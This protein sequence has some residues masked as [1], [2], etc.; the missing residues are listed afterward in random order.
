M[1]RLRHRKWFQRT[2]FLAVLALIWSQFA[3]ASHGACLDAVGPPAAV[4]AATDTGHAH[5]HGHAHAHAPGHHCHDVE[6]PSSNPPLCD[7]HC[8]EDD[9][10]ADSSRIPPV[11]PLLAGAWL[12]WFA[13][14]GIA[15]GVPV[16]ASTL[17]DSPPRPAWHRPTAHPAALLL[18]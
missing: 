8:A 18:I 5:M 2:A 4:A 14:A 3:L 11:P 17:V 1:A 10:S 13:V 9:I 12:P 16:A 15:D 6:S 7:A